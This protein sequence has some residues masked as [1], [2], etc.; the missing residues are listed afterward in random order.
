V[1]AALQG[2]RVLDLSRYL[3]GPYCTLM[4]ADYGADVVRV[5]QPNEVLKKR[6]T[7]GQAQLSDAE[8]EQLKTSEMVAR[9]KRS[10]LLDLR[11]ASARAVMQRLIEKAD[12]L[13]S[14]YRPGV[15]EGAGLGY[16]QASQINPR[17]IYCAITLC[18]QS[19]PYRDV[20]GHDPVSLAVAG[21]LSRV[22]AA[23]EQPRTI[24]VPISDINSALHAVTGILMALR[25]REVSGRGQLV[26]VAMSDTAFAFVTPALSRLMASGK[27]P[28]VG[29]NLANNGV[30][31]TRDGGYVCTTDMEPRYWDAFCDLIARPEWKPLLHQRSVYESELREIFLTRDREEWIRL[32]RG[33]GTQGAPVLSLVEAARD[34][35]ALERGVIATVRTA[36]GQ[37]VT[38]VGPL[39]KLSDTPGTIRHLAHMPGADSRD[40]LAEAGCSAQEI[41]TLIEEISAGCDPRLARYVSSS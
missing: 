27:E 28:P 14:D 20:P 3:P 33:A 32:F 2:V 21:V 1:S 15:L 38:Q 24:G 35:H 8:L 26:D 23:S 10:L 39:I 9:N 22:G 5:E 36:A 30:W 41:G 37:D 25:A 11:S 13:V 16:A 6:L 31:R 7:F 34:R 4:L 19:G 29:M 12:V 17:L 40:I 18:G